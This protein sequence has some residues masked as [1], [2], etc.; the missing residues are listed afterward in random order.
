M[1]L[2]KKSF[3]IS[4]NKEVYNL[5]DEVIASLEKQKFVSDKYYSDYKSKVF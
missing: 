1:E 4:N 3:K 5:I 2:I